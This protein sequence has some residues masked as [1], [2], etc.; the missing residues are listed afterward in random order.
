MRYRRTTVFDPLRSCGQSP[1]PPR[2]ELSTDFSTLEKD[3]KDHFEG[4]KHNR[5]K[6]GAGT[7]EGRVDLKERADR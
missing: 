3:V 1:I 2:N 7:S 6:K 5:D 4:S